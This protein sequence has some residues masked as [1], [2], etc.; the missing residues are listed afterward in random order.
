[1]E[2]I[3]FIN[4]QQP[5]LNG[6]NLNKLQQNVEDELDITN[7]NITSLSTNKLDKTSIKDTHST[8]ATDTYSCNYTNQIVESGSNKNGDWIKYANG[9]LICYG[10][11]DITAPVTY[12]DWYG[13]CRIADERT[14]TLPYTFIN[15]DYNIISTSYSFGYFGM[16]LRSKATTSFNFRACTHKNSSY[17]PGVGSFD[18]IAIGKWK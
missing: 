6:T 16:I 5:A 13:F 7:S 4:N 12:S 14:T 8:S 3:D 17:N 1:M 11:A 9:N 2:K 10:K 15:T 18:Y